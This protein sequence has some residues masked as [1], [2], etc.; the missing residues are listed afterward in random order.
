[1]TKRFPAVA[2]IAI[3]AALARA[4][5]DDHAVVGEERHRRMDFTNVE[6]GS[7]SSKR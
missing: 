5:V 2:T 7:R 4:L 3:A 1:M 6:P